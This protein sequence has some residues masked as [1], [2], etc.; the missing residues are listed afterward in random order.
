MSGIF[1]K[2][3]FLGLV[4]RVK[5]F[6]L[7]D[8]VIFHG[9][10]RKGDKFV[11]I[12]NVNPHMSKPAQKAFE[13]TW[14]GPFWKRVKDMNDKG[15]KDCI[16]RF[17]YEPIDEDDVDS[18]LAGFKIAAPIV[19]PE[20]ALIKIVSQGTIGI[21]FATS[22]T[23]ILATYGCGPCVALAGYSPKNKIGFLA[24]IQCHKE[25]TRSG[26]KILQSLLQLA[27]HS[28]DEQNPL[29]LHL[30]GG[31][32]SH[33]T[34]AAIAAWIKKFSHIPMKIK[35]QK[36]SPVWGDRYCY[37]ASYSGNRE[38]STLRLDTRTGLVGP[39]DPRS[40]RDDVEGRYELDGHLKFL[41]PAAADLE[42]LG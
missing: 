35:S 19:D 41:M 16:L 17:C 20:Q 6:R 26:K 10:Y 30:R 4:N 25:I 31:I 9:N 42:K 1:G 37:V 27:K 8:A 34:F 38:A 36:P 39:Y 40:F 3:L 13:N 11:K 24:H 15:D 21:T 18:C 23:P 32:G 28:I 7:G 14:R 12:A 22:Q 5:R 33:E 29:E 2:V